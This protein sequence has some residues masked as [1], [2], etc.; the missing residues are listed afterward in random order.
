MLNVGFAR[1][2][3]AVMVATVLSACVTLPPNHTP[4]RQD[5]WE[6]WNRGVY[7]F[8]DVLDRGV[9]KP[10]AQTYVK[11]VPEPIRTGV[12]NFFANIETPTVMVNDA[13]QGKFLAAAH[14]PGAIH[15][16][17]HGRAGGFP[18][19]GLVCRAC[20]ER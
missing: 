10:V 12:T 14:R 1:G 19:P 6:S 17:H 16:Q 11:V 5:P 15:S 13:L 9:A 7:K 18:R 8:N 4:N 2:V 3:L 20:P